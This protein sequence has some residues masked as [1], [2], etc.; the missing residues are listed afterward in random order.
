[1]R[2]FTVLFLSVIIIASCKTNKSAIS[3]I[4]KDVT[5]SEVK[6]A[7]F[8]SLFIEANKQKMLENYEKAILT[9][10]KCKTLR[11]KNG[12]TL[13][14]LSKLYQAKENLPLA[15]KEAESAVKT[16][17][18][19]KWYLLQLARLKQISNLHKEA[20]EN[21]EKIIELDPRNKQ[22]IIE[23][24]GSYEAEKK[25]EKAGNVLNNLEKITGKSPELSYQKYLFYNKSNNTKKGLEALEEI[26]EIDPQNGFANYELAKYYQNTGKSK[27]AFEKLKIAFADRNLP[28]DAKLGVLMN[29]TRNSTLN[30]E[31][32]S[33]TKELLKVMAET[34]PKDVKSYV[35]YGDFY[36]S[37]GEL[38]KSRSYYVKA[39]EFAKNSFPLYTQIM[40]LDNKL[41]NNSYLV[42]DASKAI[43]NFP[44]QPMFYLYKGIGEN[45]Q[46]KFKEAIKSFQT[47]KSVLVD[48][49]ELLFEFYSNLGNTF[50]SIKEYKKS[51]QSFENAMNINGLQPYLL[52]NYSY[53]LSVR[54]EQLEKAQEMSGKANELLPNNASFNDTYGWICFQQGKYKEAEIWLNKALNNGGNTSGTVLEHY[55]DVMSKLNK[56]KIALEF[57]EKAKLK[58]DTSDKIDLKIKEKKYHD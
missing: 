26:I 42:K 44:T 57:W 9:F 20:I 16:N 49:E 6:D 41:Q 47:G 35:A 27:L 25:F 22:V 43:E 36:N 46:K 50:H 12:A 53:Y 52:N 1:M 5:I 11:P 32:K 2:K 58:G 56:T 13:F 55:G 8:K 54:N 7:Q 38:E 39:T 51:D 15:I 4:E 31:I 10:E 17:N 24:L 3:N 33:Q 28:T 23:L 30:M 18:N 14:E 29:Y 21:Y 37:F 40:D 34:H 48:N 19:N 45:G